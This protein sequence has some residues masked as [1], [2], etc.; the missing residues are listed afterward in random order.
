MGAAGL[1]SRVK[2]VPGWAGLGWAG[3]LH[4]ALGAGWLVGELVG[5]LIGGLSWGPGLVRA[6]HWT[7]D[8]GHWAWRSRGAGRSVSQSPC[9]VWMGMDGW[10]WMDGYDMYMHLCTCVSAGAYAA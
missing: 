10:V 3:L 2:A 6:G 4:W 7:L 1:P 9:A 5:W 8:T